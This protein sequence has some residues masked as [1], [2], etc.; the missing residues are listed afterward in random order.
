MRTLSEIEE[1][2]RM[3]EQY[4]RTGTLQ[5]AIKELRDLRSIMIDLVQYIYQLW[6]AEGPVGLG[7]NPITRLDRLEEDVRRLEAGG[8]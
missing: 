6:G 4:E 3:C 8:L 7:L 2:L 1:E 5:A